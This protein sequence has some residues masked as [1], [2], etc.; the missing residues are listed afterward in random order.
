MTWEHFKPTFDAILER[1]KF[2]NQLE[3]AAKSVKGNI[4]PGGAAVC[5]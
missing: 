2:K 5:C 3:S 4:T 1:T